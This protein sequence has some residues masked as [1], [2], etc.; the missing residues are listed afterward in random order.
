MSEITIIGLD[1]AKGGYI[2]NACSITK[3]PDL[4]TVSHRKARSLVGKGSYRSPRADA[5]R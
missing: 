2:I 4:D 1:L 3:F 5:C